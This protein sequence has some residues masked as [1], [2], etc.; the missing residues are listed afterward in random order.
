MIELH[1]HSTA[2]DGTLEPAELVARARAAGVT[3]LALTDH[4]TVDGCRAALAAGEELGVRVVPGIELSVRFTPGT[5]HLLG[6]FADP[7]PPALIARMDEI[8]ASREQRNALILDRLAELG[9]P[10][11]AEDVRS[12]ASGRVGRP[13]IAAALVAAGHCADY[14]EAFD[15]YLGT[16]APACIQ[17]GSIEPVDAVRLVKECGGAASLAHPGTL[18]LE[19]A[20]LDDLV[21]TLAAAGLDGIEAFR[22]DTPLEEQEGYVA[23]ASRHGLLATGGSDYHGPLLEPLGRV[24]GSC[25]EPGPD[26]AVLEALLRRI[27]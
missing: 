10:V 25:G 2:S 8:A 3:A 13:H 19:P 4:D 22:G 12:R 6:H 5:F 23:L 16:G 18:L 7:A 15:R 24:L 17:A 27:G 20:A 26:Q 11:A 21:G 9:V 14:V 1:A